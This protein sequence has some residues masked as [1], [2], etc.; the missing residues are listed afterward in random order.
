MPQ[1]KELGRGCF[2]SV[3]LAKWR[4]VEVALKEMLHQVGALGRDFGPAALSTQRYCGTQ[5]LFSRAGVPSTIFIHE[6]IERQR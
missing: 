5:Q 1:V 6:F 3:W 2:G 4:G